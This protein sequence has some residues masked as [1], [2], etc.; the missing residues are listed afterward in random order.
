LEVRLRGMKLS[1]HLHPVPWSEKRGCLHPLPHAPSCTGLQ[2]GERGSCRDGVS[3]Q[4]LQRR[5]RAIVVSSRHSAWRDEGYHE[6]F[7]SM[8][9]MCYCL[10]I[11]F[12][13]CDVM[14]HCHGLECDYRRGLEWR[15]DLLYTRLGTASN[16]RATANLHCTRFSSLL[17]LH[18]PFPGN[19][20]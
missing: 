11:L 10:A 4:A 1:A 19:G 13:S 12:R 20:F 9:T 14:S 17:C 8:A 5:G 18:Q 2:C 16:Y 15:L 7:F 3:K 6:K